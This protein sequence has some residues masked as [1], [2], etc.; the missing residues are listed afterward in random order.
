VQRIARAALVLSASALCATLGVTARERQRETPYV[1]ILDEHPQI[2]YALRPTH[3]R[4]AALNQAIADG[5]ATLTFDPKGGYLKSVL[6]AFGLSPDSQILVFSKTGIQ[7]ASTSPLNPRSLYFDSSLVVGFISEAKLLEIAA[8]DPEQ[9]MVFYTIDQTPSDRPVLT[10]RSMCLT[11]HVSGGTL[12]VPGVINRSVFTRDDGSPIPQLG[13]FDVDHRTRLLDRWGGMFVTG[14]YTQF[15]YNVAVHAG[16]LSVPNEAA[17][18]GTASNEV[19]IKW[20][21]SEPEKRGYLSAES[22]IAAMMVFDHQARAINLLTRLNWE[23]R[24]NGDW[25]AIATDLAD[26]L[27]F[28]DEAPPPA[29]ITPRTAYATAFA[30]ATPKDR[31]GRSFGELDLE[32]RLLRYP[33]S[34]MI[35]TEAFDQLPAVAKQAVYNRM[36]TILSGRDDAK[37]YAHLSLDDRRAMVEILRD[38]KQDLP[39][40]FSTRTEQ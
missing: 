15:P 21:N 22:D 40:S 33:C 13:F 35:Y 39:D 3:D 26:Y 6:A 19:F 23:V 27:L 8:H 28:V 5:K 12:D 2:Q 34:Y 30:A 9:G 7:R 38:T 31:Q 17:G 32:K 25:Q 14:N 24:T 20:L 11:C 36:W 18:P 10:R 37:K 29:R 1:G 16:N 4:A